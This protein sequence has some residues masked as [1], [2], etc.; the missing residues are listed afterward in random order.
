[1]VR[2]FRTPRNH[3]DTPAPS[4]L[5]PSAASFYVPTLPD[6]HQDAL[7][8][9]H[10]YAGHLNADPNAAG[11]PDTTVTAHIYFVLIKARRIADRERIMFWFNV[12]ITI[13][14]GSKSPPCVPYREDPGVHPLTDS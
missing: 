11:L 10:I 12:S 5:V 6:L 14:P 3:S 7:H 1:M 13:T 2:V 9:L 8:P 4:I